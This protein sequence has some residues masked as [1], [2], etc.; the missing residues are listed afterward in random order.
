MYIEHPAPSDPEALG[1]AWIGYW[2]DDADKRTARPI[3]TVAASPLTELDALQ[4]RLGLGRRK[5]WV[6]TRESLMFEGNQGE[7]KVP[8]YQV[9]GERQAAIG[10]DGSDGFIA[11]S[12][13]RSFTLAG[14]RITL[15][16]DRE[17]YIRQWLAAVSQNLTK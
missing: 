13:V 16:T 6:L 11:I 10:I 4:E 2:D 9:R 15:V 14:Q 5:E 8:I 12:S 3:L 7:Q 17:P 1:H